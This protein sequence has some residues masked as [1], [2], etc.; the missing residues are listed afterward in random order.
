MEI[1]CECKFIVNIKFCFCYRFY[2]RF[3]F[4]GV[5]GCIDGPHFDI[6]KPNEEIEHVFYCRKHFH[7]LNVQMVGSFIF[8]KQTNKPF[9]FII[10]I[11]IY[12]TY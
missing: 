6:F 7:S 9:H 4:L 3:G 10:L 8:N 2:E 5:V 11:Q 1:V 12:P